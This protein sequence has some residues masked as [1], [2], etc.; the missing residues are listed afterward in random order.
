MLFTPVGALLC[1]SFPKIYLI[2]TTKHLHR[3]T[4]CPLVNHPQPSPPPMG[5]SDGALSGGHHTMMF[6]Y[7]EEPTCRTMKY[8]SFKSTAYTYQN[9]LQ[10]IWDTGKTKAWGEQS[11][12]TVVESSVL[13]APT[14]GLSLMEGH[15]LN[16]PLPPS[17]H[18]FKTYSWGHIHRHATGETVDPH[19]L[20]VWHL[21]IWKSADAEFC[22]SPSPSGPSEPEWRCKHL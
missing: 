21:Q 4:F 6:P 20:R 19:Y 16:I 1:P 7:Y 17:M 15:R 10:W 8:H 9:E 18:Q 3:S 12:G 11:E 13:V 5:S 14:L 22:P 2:W